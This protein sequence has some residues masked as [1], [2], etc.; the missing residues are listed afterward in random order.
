VSG[1]SGRAVKRTRA[2]ARAWLAIRRQF[3]KD[4]ERDVSWSLTTSKAE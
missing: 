4:S 2:F 1:L 3:G